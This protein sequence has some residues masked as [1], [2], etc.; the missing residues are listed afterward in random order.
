MSIILYLGEEE[1]KNNSIL[2]CSIG[3]MVVIITELQNTGK[4]ESLEKRVDNE[5]D[6]RYCDFKHMSCK[7][8]DIAILKFRS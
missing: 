8:L 1:F 2:V 4:R 3:G 7:R 6:S 5:F